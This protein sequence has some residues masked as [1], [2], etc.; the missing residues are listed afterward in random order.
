MRRAVFVAFLLMLGSAVL[1]ATVLRE[2]FA[3][4]ATPFQSVLVANTADN[5]VLVKQQ[6]TA[7]VKDVLAPGAKPFKQTFRWLTQPSGIRAEQAI[8]PPVGAGETLIVTH[9]SAVGRSLNAAFDVTGGSCVLFLYAGTSRD[10]V[11]AYQGMTTFNTFTVNEELTFPLDEG[12]S[13]ALNCLLV[14][15]TDAANN[16]FGATTGYVVPAS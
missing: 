13:L 7:E 3:W 6:G 2:P 1:G 15:G 11:G 5:P 9:L 10:I 8:T 14:S 12:E 16:M 4:A